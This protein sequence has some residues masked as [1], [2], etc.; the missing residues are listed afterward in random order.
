MK[1]L[2]G[3]CLKPV[4]LLAALLGCAAVSPAIAESKVFLELKA[5]DIKG[6]S[7]EANHKNWIDVSAPQFEVSAEVSYLKGAGVSIGKPVPDALSWTQPLDASVP[8]LAKQMTAGKALGTA[9]FDFTKQTS[10]APGAAPSSYMTITTKNS[11]L[12]DLSYTFPSHEAPQVDA[13]M[14]YKSL[15]LAYTPIGAGGKP[16][17]K[18]TTTWD[19]ATGNVNVS[20]GSAAVMGPGSTG[21]GSGLFLRFGSPTGA[22]AGES[23]VRDYENWIEVSDASWGMSADSSWTKG[24]GASVGKVMP[25]TF[26]WTQAMDRSVPYTLAAIA[27]GKA[28]PTATFE[29]VT[30]TSSGPV[31]LM[32][33]VMEAPFLTDLELADDTVSESMVFRS[34]RQTVWSLDKSGQVTKPVSF[35]WNFSTGKAEGLASPDVKGFGSGGV[36]GALAAAASVDAPLPAAPIP[37]PETWAM[38]L[39]GLA[40]LGGAAHRRRRT[41]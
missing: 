41:A 24:G 2:H 19:V 22:I 7:T 27:G 25:D 30:Q 5:P 35:E 37:E 28:L 38:M 29:Y 16:G 17:D 36:G 34:I 1:T 15:E 13:S 10:F 18:V 11:F 26:S 21:S 4:A 20:G 32:Q 8:E 6:S 12:T 23:T 9:K 31:T 39:C 3:T 14:V 40:L 33:M